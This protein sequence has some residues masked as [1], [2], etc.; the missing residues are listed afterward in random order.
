M[1][2]RVLI[3]INT[4]NV[5]GA[6]T[7]IMKVFRSIDRSKL[8]FDFLVCEKDRGVYEDEVELLGGCV[9]HGYYKVN[10]PL[11]NLYSI[12]N[13]VRKG[14]YKTV[15]IFS[16]H[17]IVVL[18]LLVSRL[19]GARKRVV[20]STNSAC[21]GKTSNIIASLT[22]P[23][24]N[25]LIT[26]RIAPSKEAALWLFGKRI[27]R[28]GE[29]T[30][31]NNGLDLNDFKFNESNRNLFRKEL[32]V[33]DEIVI[34]HVGR[35][36]YQKNHLFLIDIFKDFHDDNKNSKLV[37]IGKGE[38][39]DQV[40]HK[41]N[42][43][44]INDAVIYLDVRSD[45]P[46]CLSGFDAFLFPSLYEGMPNTVVEAQACG[47]P[48][49]ISDT[50]TKEAMITD[51]VVMKSLE[52]PPHMWAN[53]LSRMIDKSRDRETYCNEMRERGYSINSVCEELIN[54]LL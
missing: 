18:D 43:L 7:F 54:I 42:N 6:E 44:G 8:I 21:G 47:L 12:Y 53:M 45:I 40:V 27:V 22:R 24:M 10:N 14:K 46:Y 31:L 30:I 23:L 29:Y 52:E 51:L 38:T 20:R 17:P 50:I 33:D 13:T 3:I 19:G 26:V 28:K 16:Q 39:K 48:C 41:V 2:Q 36:N 11:K 35:F 1:A 32:N 4:L 9:Y 49:L 34:G 5:G 15:F 37:L 25:L